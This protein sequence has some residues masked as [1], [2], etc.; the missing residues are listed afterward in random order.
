MSSTAMNST[1]RA[2]SAGAVARSIKNNSRLSN[3]ISAPFIYTISIPFKRLHA[4]N[5]R[6]TAY[7]WCAL[8]PIVEGNVSTDSHG[9]AK[10]MRL[11]QM[12]RLFVGALVFTAFHGS[13]LAFDGPFGPWTNQDIG[14]TGARGAASYTNGV[15]TVNGA[16]A[17]IWG[18]ADAFHYVYRSFAGDCALVARITQVSNTDSFARAGVMFRASLAPNSPHAFMLHRAGGRT[19]FQ[20]RLDNGEN[21]WTDGSW[22]NAPY[23]VKLERN[24]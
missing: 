10:L 8:D 13:V 22:V 19:A 18:A 7:R 14:Q 3:R 5:S 20:A 21:T 17:D 12:R 23:W 9:T 11:G 16:G 24:Q 6:H 1:F 4:L 15:F 2:P